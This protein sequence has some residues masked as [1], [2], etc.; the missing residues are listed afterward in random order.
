MKNTLKWVRF[1]YILSIQVT[2]R[3][4]MPLYKVVTF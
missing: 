3:L 2:E 4:Y 1:L